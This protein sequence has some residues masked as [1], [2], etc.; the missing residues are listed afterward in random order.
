MISNTILCRFSPAFIFN[1]DET[2]VS[3]SS[4]H[5]IRAIV[6]KEWKSAPSLTPD[7]R[8]KHITFIMCVSADGKHIPTTA[9]LPELKSLPMGLNSIVDDIAW[10]SSPSGWINDDIYYKWVDSIFIPFL[11]IKRVLYDAPDAPALLWMDGHGSRSDQR[12]VSALQTAGVATVIIPAHT[13]HIL[14]PL[15]CGVNRALKGQIAK[16]FTRPSSGGL[17]ELREALMTSAIRAHYHAVADHIVVGSFRDAGLFPWDP[18]RIL[19]DPTK[20]ND[21]TPAA[22]TTQ[23]RGTPSG[24]SRNISGRI[25]VSPS[26]ASAAALNVVPTTHVV[27]T[28]SSVPQ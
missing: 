19:S 27:M 18:E 4:R 8:M 6:P 5:K 2:M 26:L 17:P 14:Q 22:S 11:K 10:T 21:A 24:N 13:S 15:D 25:L 3:L 12:A 1:M 23:S 9:I 7:D 28:S 16:H 20:V